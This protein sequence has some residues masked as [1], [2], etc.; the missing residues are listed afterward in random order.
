M[1]HD[2]NQIDNEKLAII[3]S[4]AVIAALDKGGYISIAIVGSLA[5]VTISKVPVEISG[6]TD[7]KDPAQLG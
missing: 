3:V 1:S 5:E 4:S 7:I 2:I 6:D